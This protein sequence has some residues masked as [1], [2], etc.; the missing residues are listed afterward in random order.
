[1]IGGGN[2]ITDPRPVA[3]KDP[4]R[5]A[6]RGLAI[7][8][9]VLFLP[10]PTV[11]IANG[12][13]ALSRALGVAL[14]AVASIA[15]WR[16]GRSQV[17]VTG[18]VVVVRNVIRT[19]TVPARDVRDVEAAPSVGGLR[20]CLNLRLQDGS[21]VPMTALPTPFNAFTGQPATNRHRDQLVDAIRSASS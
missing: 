18:K 2:G 4:G 21:L 5:W 14:F 1:M 8:C 20:R 16:T 3:W 9:A 17:T 12:R 19:Y 7:L 11:E 10:V 13:P 15:L 6:W